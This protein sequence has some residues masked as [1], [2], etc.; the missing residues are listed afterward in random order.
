MMQNE[1]TIKQWLIPKLTERRLTV[2]QFANKVGVSRASIYFYFTDKAR[3]EVETMAAMCAVLNV[4]LKEGL[5][6][7][8][9]KPVGRPGGGRKTSIN[10]EF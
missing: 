10:R 2:E 8:T 3:P 4:P 9:P 6:Q 7:Y 5:N 1:N